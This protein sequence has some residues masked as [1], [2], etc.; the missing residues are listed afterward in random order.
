MC[1][2]AQCPK[3]PNRQR[4]KEEQMEQALHEVFAHLSQNRWISWKGIRDLLKEKFGENSDISQIAFFIFQQIHKYSYLA[5]IAPLKLKDSYIRYGELCR[6]IYQAIAFCWPFVFPRE[7]PLQKI[8]I[9][10]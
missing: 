6:I 4:T 9:A 2:C 8:N 10:R 7:Q 3:C 1:N 5:Q